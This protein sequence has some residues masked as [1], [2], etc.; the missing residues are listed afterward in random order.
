[1]CCYACHTCYVHNNMYKCLM[2]VLLDVWCVCLN[3]FFYVCV[4][5]VAIHVICVMYIILCTYVSC[6]CCYACCVYVWT[7]V[8]RVHFMCGCMCHG[9]NYTYIYFMPCSTYSLYMSFISWYLICVLYVYVLY[10]CVWY[11]SCMYVSLISLPHLIR[12]HA[13]PQIWGRYD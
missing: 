7:C 1:M 13:R 11:M 2:Y 12:A 3:M 8:E 4:L 9:L 5:C 6:M 10:V